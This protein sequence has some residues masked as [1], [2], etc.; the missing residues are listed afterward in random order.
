MRRKNCGH[1]VF[2]ISLETKAHA[3]L[4]RFVADLGKPGRKVSLAKVT[5]HNRSQFV[6]QQRGKVLKFLVLNCVLFSG[7]VEVKTKKNIAHASNKAS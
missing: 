1:K 3:S 2:S 4:T 6:Y 5:Q 7:I